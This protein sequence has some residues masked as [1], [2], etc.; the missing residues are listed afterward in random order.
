MR[1]RIL[2]REML[3]S[4]ADAGRQAPVWTTTLSNTTKVEK[5]CLAGRRS[6]M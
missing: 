2:K 1:G 3:V 6:C 5:Y 4:K